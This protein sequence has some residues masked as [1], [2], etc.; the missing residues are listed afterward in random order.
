MPE[1]EAARLAALRESKILDTAPEAAFDDITRLAAHICSTP[2]ALVSLIDID[3]QWNK[4]KVGMD[5]TETPRDVAFCAHT[6]V[7]S[8]ILIVPDTLT[9]KRF[10]T[11][12]LVTS[13]PHIRFYA[14]VPLI[15]A[16]GYALGTLCVIDYVPRE[17]TP[18][19]VEAQQTLGRQVVRQIEL[20]RNLADLQ[21][22]AVKRQGVHKKQLQFFKQI[23][24]GL[25]SLLVVAT[26]VLSYFGAIC[27]Y[28]FT[29][30]AVYYFI[31]RLNTER[32]H[33]EAALEQ[34]RDFTAAVLDTAAALVVVLDLQGRIIRFNRACEQTT[35]Y[36]FAEVRGKYFWNLFLISKEEVVT[37][38]AVFENFRAGHTN[39]YEN[40]WVTRNGARRLIT[41]SNTALLDKQG[42]VEYL[43]STGIDITERKLQEAL[44][45]ANEKLTNWV[46]EL[47]Q[48]NSEI[49]LLREMSDV[50]Q[51]CFT[52]EEAYTAIAQF[53]QRLFPQTSGGIFL[54]VPQTWSLPLLLGALHRSLVRSRL[55][56]TSAG[57]CDVVGHILLEA[58]TRVCCANIYTRTHHPLNHSAYR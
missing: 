13:D 2:T 54:S 50:L 20:R 21:R 1:N 51:A 42:A 43:I 10:A 53:V 23:A 44:Q 30:A 28:C 18:Q 27:L 29:L 15:T 7:Q 16:A 3:R 55:H 47:E 58:R 38:K 5:A 9:D 57:L 35:G 46:N 8:D 34:E 56:P 31:H 26:G 25:A 4:S 48:R 19:Q 39:Q 33:T 41:W 12:P 24:L 37:V 36:S 11:N 6:I 17:L 32:Q 49:A 40:Y 14:G 45:Q 52:V 22:T